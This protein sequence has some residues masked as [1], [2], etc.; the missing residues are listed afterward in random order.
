MPGDILVLTKP[1]GTQVAVNAHEW[2]LD[3]PEKWNRIKS[4]VS[5]EEVR[6]AYQRGIDSMCR[7]NR[8]GA[9][10]MHKYNSHGSTDVTGEICAG[11]NG[12]FCA[13]KA[14]SRVW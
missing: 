9:Q 7:L 3:Y 14:S 5:E 2:L 12:Q 1:L 13:K 11:L 6:M 8:I 10:L 4:V